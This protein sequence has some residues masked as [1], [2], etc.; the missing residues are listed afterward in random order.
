[1]SPSDGRRNDRD[2]VLFVSLSGWLAGPGRSIATLISHLPPHLQP[3]LACPAQGNLLAAVRSQTPR[4]D[5]VDLPRR[6]GQQSHPWSRVQAVT[7]LAQW[8]VKN[9]RRIK[10]IHA[11]GFSDLHVAAPGLILTRLPVVVWFHGS[12]EN[13]WDRTLSRLWRRL[14][15][16]RRLAA[17][18]EVARAR[19]VS[20]GIGR[21]DQIEIIPNPID[22]R[23]VVAEKDDETN[24]SRDRVVVGYMG[25]VRRLKGF[26]QLPALVERL[27]DAPVS[28]AIFDSP[29][30]NEDEAER[31]VWD[32]LEA[33]GSDRVRILGRQDDVRNAYRV[34]DIVIALSAAESFN[35]AMAEAMLNGIPVVATDI[36]AHR[37]LIGRNEGGLLF[38][39]GDLASASEAIRSLIMDKDLRIALG[40]AAPRR[41]EGPTDHRRIL[42]RFV[43]LYESFS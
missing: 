30:G 7:V 18:A 26:F 15:P 12:E 16:D 5:H 11:N 36:G 39:P 24:G 29:S 28:W 40:E 43:E 31:S 17:V 13:S 3:V 37:A 2:V 42:D 1:M 14:L 10:A 23:D 41:V 9:K 27:T 32:R 33:A 19:A 6:P 35:R 8:M 22:P 21:L 38:P 4:A 20:G 34:C 25:G